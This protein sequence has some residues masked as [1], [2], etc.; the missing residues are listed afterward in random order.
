MPTLK[1]SDFMADGN[2]AW[3]THSR[4]GDVYVCVARGISVLTA[5]QSVLWSALRAPWDSYD[6]RHTARPRV[7]GNFGPE[8]MAALYAYAKKK[9]LDSKILA[10][11]KADGY[12]K[13]ISIGTLALAVWLTYYQPKIYDVDIAGKRVQRL[14]PAQFGEVPAA[15]LVIPNNAV[16]WKWLWRPQVDQ[17][18]STVASEMPT[19]GLKG[20]D[21]DFGTDALAPAV[22]ANQAGQGG[23][24]SAPQGNGSSSSSTSNSTSITGSSN[25][26]TNTSQIS[27]NKVSGGNGGLILLLLGGAGVAYLAMRSD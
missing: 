16:L 19:C 8:T 22:S 11:I 14:D 10:G 21:W 24:G 17:D 15:S 5:L 27:Q 4:A 2:G 25:T 18:I 26:T 1:R 6:G 12:A 9:G 23:T 3:W 13:R 7:D 20:T